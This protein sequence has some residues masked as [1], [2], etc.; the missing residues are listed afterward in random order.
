MKV[1]SFAAIAALATT[2]F[3]VLAT[4][5]DPVLFQKMWRADGFGCHNNDFAPN[6][7]NNTGVAT[8]NCTYLTFNTDNASI[9][10]VEHC[11][12]HTSGLNMTTCFNFGSV[13]LKDDINYLLGL[14]LTNDTFGFR[15]PKGTGYA[16]R[17]WAKGWIYNKERTYGTYY[18]LSIASGQHDSLNTTLPL[19]PLSWPANETASLPLAIALLAT[20][21]A[22]TEPVNFQKIWRADGLGC[23]QTSYTPACVD[24][25]NGMGGC[26]YSYF[27]MDLDPFMEYCV[28]HGGRMN[29]TTCF[30]F[31]SPVQ[32][33]DSRYMIEQVI[34]SNIFGFRIGHEGAGYTVKG[35][36]K[37]LV[38][39]ADFKYSSY[40][41]V[42]I[43]AGKHDSLGTTLPSKSTPQPSQVE[44]IITPFKDTC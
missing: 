14:I 3:A 28:S 32:Q 15:S 27:T 43:A 9:P 34:T 18:A 11:L 36:A 4:A 6:C 26:A 44:T 40:Y 7:M 19:T 30:V 37:G 5:A 39:S 16:S 23:R 2:L 42:S 38:Y 17:G 10:T 12:F 25:I 29:I 41:A 21:V 33:Q 1:F 35:W 22:A 31:D 8:G 24:L 20:L 13:V